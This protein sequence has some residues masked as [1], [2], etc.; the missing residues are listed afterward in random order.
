MA[1]GATS[2]GL[3]SRAE[4]ARAERD[5]NAGQPLVRGVAAVAPLAAI[6]CRALPRERRDGAAAFGA[7]RLPGGAAAAAEGGDPS[8]ASCSECSAGL[9][10]EPGSTCESWDLGEHPGA[11]GWAQHQPRWERCP[12]PGQSAGRGCPPSPGCARPPA[13]SRPSVLWPFSCNNVMNFSSLM[14]FKVF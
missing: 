14:N 6:L 7:C 2:A 10:E 11:V 8:P 3:M 13:R 4:S 5:A 1:V 12:Q 9:Q